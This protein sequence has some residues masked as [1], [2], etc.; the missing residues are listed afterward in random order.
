MS[1]P[2]ILVVEDEAVVA[3]NIG[4]ELSELGYGVC[5]LAACGEDALKIA[6]ETHPDL[7]LMD[8]VLNGELDGVETTQKIHEQMDVPVVYMT[9]YA[10][11]H[12]L[13]RAKKTAPFGYLLKPYEERELHTTI[14]IALQKHRT[15]RLLR[16]THDWLDSTLRWMP[17]AVILTDAQAN[18]GFINPMAEILTGW[19]PEEALGQP[20]DRVFHLVHKD[21]GEPMRD[22]GTQALRTGGAIVIGEEWRLIMNDGGQKPIEGVVST[23]CDRGGTFTGWVFLFRDVSERLRTEEALRRC[24]DQLR[25]WERM[26][27]AGRVAAGMAHDFNHLLTAILGNIAMVLA[28]MPEDD[29]NRSFLATAE[30]A[31]LQAAEVTKR[32]LT[33]AVRKKKRMEPVNLN[34]AVGE[35]TEFLCGVMNPN[36]GLQVTQAPDLWPV[37][38]DRAQLKEVILNLCLNARDAMPERGTLLLQTE[39]VLREEDGRNTPLGLRRQEFACLRVSD[40]GGGIPADV[41]ARMFEPFFTTKAPDRGTGMGLAVVAAI[42]ENHGGWIDCHSEIG[43]GTRFE[44]Y[45]PRYDSGTNGEGAIENGQQ[46]TR[47]T[48]LATA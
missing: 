23:V 10:D 40:T 30:K 35:I 17:D 14:Q 9:A 13:E 4:K 45:L 42:V 46:M 11:D 2:Q 12:T 32:L 15:E 7:V 18:V 28:N 31:A 48:R 8:I 39:N 47:R 5:G 22:L 38:G 24:E 29:R 43:Q 6:A 36:I 21:T 16:E 1:S 27:T 25:R 19:T 26:E 37:Y 3:K 44:V 34:T 41:Q 33:F 20:W